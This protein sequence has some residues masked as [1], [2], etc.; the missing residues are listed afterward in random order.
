VLT[1]AQDGA[2][3]A[4]FN[5]FEALTARPPSDHTIDIT[6]QADP[7]VTAVGRVRE[8]S[9]TVD[10]STGTVRVKIGLESTPPAMGLGAVVVG[11][12]QFSREE[13]VVLPWSALY[14]Y[15]NEPAVWI[16]DKAKGTVSVRQVV[17]ARYGPNLIV[18]KSGV[19]PG[20]S[21]VVAGIQF[22]RPGQAVAA[23]DLG[24]PAFQGVAAPAA[25]Q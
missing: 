13:A 10:A 18:L 5:V 20:E 3:D 11:R 7:S 1:V 12:A 6:L 9:P 4:V 16:Y 17:I 22:L 21:V 15:G 23:I 2:R 19:E 14:R 24:Q 25:K 8:I